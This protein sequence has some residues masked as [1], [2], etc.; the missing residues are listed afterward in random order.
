M[1]DGSNPADPVGK[2]S[3]TTAGRLLWRTVRGGLLIYLGIMLMFALFE[4]SLVYFPSRYPDGDWSLQPGMEDAWFEAADGTRLHG[5]YFQVDRPRA[6]VLF[7]HGNGASI[8]WRR[9]LIDAFRELQVSALLWSY[10]GY[11]R[12]EGS[13]HESGILQDARAARAWLAN[14]SDVSA[15]DI[16]LWGESLGGAVAVDLAQEGARGLILEHTFTTMPDV[17]HWHYPWLPARTMMRNRFN[18]IEKI[19]KYRGPLLQFHGN[20]DRVVPYSIGQQLFAAAN[21]PKQFVTIEKGDHNDPRTF[22]VFEA[23]DRFLGSLPPLQPR[24]D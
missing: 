24:Q 12:S 8:A 9:G 6:V 22:A 2:S 23:I 20:A 3:G 1:A 7:C 13:P 14:R 10:R 17:A 19:G 11:G 21:E 4:N 18:S 16:V 5:W 15:S